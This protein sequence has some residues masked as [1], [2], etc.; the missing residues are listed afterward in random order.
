MVDFIIVGQGIAGTILHFKLSKAGFDAIVID[1]GDRASSKV[2]AGLINPITGR[3]YV[4][5]W[6][7]DDLI[8]TARATYSQLSDYLGITTY[9]DMNI[10]R[11]LPTIKDENKWCSRME[12]PEAVNYIG[13]EIISSD[14][15][16]IMSE[17]LNYGIVLEGMQVHLAAIIKAYRERLS[18]NNQIKEAEFVYDDLEIK[19]DHVTYQGIK[20]KAIIFAEGHRAVSNPLWQDLPFVP[21][22]GEVL[23]IKL[24]TT[25]ITDIVKNKVFIIP[26][27]DDTYWVGSGYEWYY[28]NEIPTHVGKEKLVN[29]LNQLLKVP[30]EIVDHKAGIRPSVD[31]QR[32]LI[33]PHRKYDNVYIFNGM[34]TKG[35]SLTPYWVDHFV[36]YIQEHTELDLEVKVRYS[37]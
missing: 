22:K 30:Y 10:F 25:R 13:D 8:P 6:K 5:S 4:K 24:P 1:D 28:E 27:L 20:S 36:S 26:M 31:N 32:P 18:S 19:D 2:A 21:V 37:N 14:I 15:E 16:G 11:A 7:I 29:T 23:L 3:K 9:R 12:D 33:G 35:S 34:G 17:E